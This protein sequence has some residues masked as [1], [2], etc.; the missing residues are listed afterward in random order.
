[1]RTCKY[2]IA[3][4]M[5]VAELTLSPNCRLNTASARKLSDSAGRAESNW[6]ALE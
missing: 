3:G 4:L 2:A 5:Y 6:A 1:M